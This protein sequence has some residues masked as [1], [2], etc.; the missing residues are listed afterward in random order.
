[1]STCQCQS[2]LHNHVAGECPYDVEGEGGE[3]CRSCK[4]K[5]NQ[6]RWEA[7]SNLGGDSVGPPPTRRPGD[8]AA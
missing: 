4:D 1:M 6:L 2:L 8:D 5:D 7:L 3:K